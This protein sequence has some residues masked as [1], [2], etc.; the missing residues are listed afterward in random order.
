MHP[1]RQSKTVDF[2]GHIYVRKQYIYRD[3]IQDAD[4]LGAISCLDDLKAH[5]AQVACGYQTQKNVTFYNQ[6]N[7]H[8]RRMH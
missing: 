7:R 5:L 1:F 6:H 8:G 2:A 3:T 4:C